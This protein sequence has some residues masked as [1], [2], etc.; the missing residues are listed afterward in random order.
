[1]HVYSLCTHTQTVLGVLYVVRRNAKPTRL[2]VHV[3]IRLLRGCNII[4]C[5]KYI[6][7]DSRHHHDIGCQ[8]AQG[9]L[10]FRHTVRTVF[11]IIFTM[12]AHFFPS[13][14]IYTSNTNTIER[15]NDEWIFYYVFF[16]TSLDCRVAANDARVF[17]SSFSHLIF[18][19]W[20]PLTHSIACSFFISVENNYEAQHEGAGALVN[21][22]AAPT[23]NTTTIAEAVLRQAAHVRGVVYINPE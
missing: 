6:H 10:P 16:S 18:G 21:T 4:F 20:F 15:N 13:R 11:I 17:P 9:S 1:M 12:Y 23:T 8:T 14:Q 22:T 2:T 19:A 3:R 5:N 7:T